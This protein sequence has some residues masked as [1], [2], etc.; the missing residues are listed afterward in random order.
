MVGGGRV[1]VGI[2]EG[3][4][5]AGSFLLGLVLLLV[6]FLVWVESGRRSAAG[7]AQS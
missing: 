3:V 7:R 1:V 2:G 5:L 4:G 6:W